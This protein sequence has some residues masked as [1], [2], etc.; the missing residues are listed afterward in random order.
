MTVDNSYGIAGGAVVLATASHSPCSTCSHQG[1]ELNGPPRSKIGLKVCKT[2]L[3]DGGVAPQYCTTVPDS[4]AGPEVSSEVTGSEGLT[5][6]TAEPAK[7]NSREL[8]LPY[9]GSVP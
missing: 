4:A 8:S 3:L 7:P 1:S 5:Y 6:G 2:P 9:P